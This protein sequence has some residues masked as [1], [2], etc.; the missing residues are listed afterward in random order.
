MK[1]IRRPAVLAVLA[2]AVSAVA[3]IMAGL[4]IAQAAA[5]SPVHHAAYFAC[6]SN[7]GNGTAGPVTGHPVTCP[8]G[9]ILAEDNNPGPAGAAGPSGVVGVATHDLGAV[10]SVP[11]GGPFAAGKT[12][13]GTVPLKA[14]TYEVSVNAKATPLTSSAVEVFPQFFAYDGAALADFSNDLFNVGSG[15]LASLNTTID[16]YF[17][18]SRVITLAADSSINFYAFGYDSDQGAGS[19]KLDD[20]AVT[21][22]Q[23]QPAT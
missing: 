1:I 21:A 17:S 6:F 20:L 5:P 13:V 8:S 23:L 10:A 12:L 16:S 15:P 14:G 9:S 19:Y 7:G 2:I 11:T 22:V 18:G 4:S 3:V